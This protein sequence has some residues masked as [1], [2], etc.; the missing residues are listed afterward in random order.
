MYST[1]LSLFTFCLFVSAGGVLLAYDCVQSI[2]KHGQLMPSHA[3]TVIV[4]L[5]Y[6]STTVFLVPHI[7]SASHDWYIKSSILPLGSQ[8]W[9]L[10]LWSITLFS[11]SLVVLGI[12]RKK[13][14]SKFRPASS[15]GQ[16]LPKSDSQFINYSNTILLSSKPRKIKISNSVYKL[17]AFI[18]VFTLTGHQLI[19][20]YIALLQG[21]L[22]YQVVR[23]FTPDSQNLNILS[24]FFLRY[25][26]VFLPVSWVLLF[27]ICSKLNHYI[28]AVILLP[29][30]VLVV[31][32][33]PFFF[34]LASLILIVFIKLIHDY[35]ILSIFKRP[36]I[37]TKSFL[38]LLPLAFAGFLAFG[39]YTLTNP[40][41]NWLSIFGR[42]VFTPHY[43][44]LSKLYFWQLENFS[45]YDIGGS[46]LASIFNGVP[47]EASNYMQETTFSLF[48][49]V[50]GDS[51]MFL[52][53]ALMRGGLLLVFIESIG[54][55]LF[56]LMLDYI[57]MQFRQ[58]LLVQ[59]FIIILALYT[60]LI[61]LSVDS[62]TVLLHFSVFYFSIALFL[63][64][65]LRRLRLQR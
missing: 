18:L 22:S 53:L 62:Q 38:F 50:F 21:N 36:I 44:S 32:K 54:I 17:S 27:S 12:V 34:C 3:F 52:P 1:S 49:I 10:Y 16:S 47:Y 51:S 14:F 43:S 5:L 15:F 41:S 57:Y 37:K 40:E 23:G 30:N 48:G 55:V 46:R 24:Q 4:S 39:A 26:Y 19:E 35:K 45:N 11:F 33:T 42:Y 25:S 31:K 63:L 60:S 56:F 28:L 65:F 20:S 58:N 61:L 7:S 64:A 6:I 29:L 2:K 8:A 13:I 59:R 9:S